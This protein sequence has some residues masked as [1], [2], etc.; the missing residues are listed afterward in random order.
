MRFQFSSCLMLATCFVAIFVTI[1]LNSQKYKLATLA[2]LQKF[3]E[4]KTCAEFSVMVNLM[5][6]NRKSSGLACMTDHISIS[7]KI[8]Y[9][10]WITRIKIIFS[11]WFEKS[12]SYFKLKTQNS[13]NY[14]SISNFEV[15]KKFK[16]RNSKKIKVYQQQEY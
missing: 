16:R 11:A 8:C 13:K 1:L 12:V 14:N 7:K 10:F 9:F 15:L 4:S 3:G 5:Y 2:P 6:S